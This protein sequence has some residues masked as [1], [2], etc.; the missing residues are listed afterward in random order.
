M[1]I[2]ICNPLY[3]F[4]LG[5]CYEKYFVR[6]GARW[7]HSGIK[8]KGST[9]HYLPFPFFLAYSAAWLRREGFEVAALDCVALGLGADA[10]LAE[11]RREKP[12]LVFFETATP[13]ISYDL[14]TARRLKAAL[15]GSRLIIGGPHTTVYDEDALKAAPEV[16]FVVRGEYEEA[17]VE[18]ARA[19][20]DGGDPDKVAGIT[21]REPGGGTRNTGPRPLLEPLDKLPMPAYDLFPSNAAPDPGLY[22]DGFC[23]HR[24]A[25]QMHASRGCPYKCDFC[26]WN[27]VM[28]GNGRYRTFSP[29]RLLDEIA[30]LCERYG[31]REIYFDDDDFTINAAHVR[32]IAEGI[33][34]RGLDIKWSCMGDAI[35]ITPDLLALMARSGCVGMKFGVE[36]GSERMIKKLGKPV[37]LGKVRDLVKLCATHGIKTHATF[38]LGLAEDDLQSIG[39]TIAFLEDFDC[40]TIQVSV[41]TPLPGT[42]FFATAERENLLK[43]KDWEKY[44]GKAGD[45]VKHRNLDLD[46]VTA[47]RSRALRRWVFNRLTSPRWLLRQA[48]YFFRILSG[49]GPAFIWEQARSIIEEEFLIPRVLRR[50][51]KGA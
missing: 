5:G 15:P 27:Q 48:G 41:C 44:D 34:A 3:T 43:T 6:S 50:G 2:L 1:K 47:M 32:A 40:D 8:R 35:N 24:P 19:L 37:D 7:P 33:I 36:T 38:T 14:D 39:E 16:D 26:L 18:L 11:A 21:Y 20:R 13:T 28:Y 31:S 46:E 30:H 4:D 25:I 17:L 10:L 51:A 23:Q 12:D 9:P 45:V 29:G 49:M 22:W 42:R